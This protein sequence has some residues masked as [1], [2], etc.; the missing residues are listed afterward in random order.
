MASRAHIQI[1]FEDNGVDVQAASILPC[2]ESGGECIFIGRTRHETSAKHGT[3]VALQYDCY[4]TMAETEVHRLAV[5]AI[6]RFAVHAVHV[7]H[8]IGL[9]AIGEAS[10]VIAVG[11][12]HRDDAF[13]ACRFM[14]DMLKLRVPIWKQEQWADGSTWSKGV[15][16]QSI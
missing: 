13:L 15:R 7:T 1:K 11:S 12:D 5:E 4:Q 10:V 6:D 9:V 8:S 16:L 14:I 2:N 3:L